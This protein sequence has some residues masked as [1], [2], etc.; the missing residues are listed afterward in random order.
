MQCYTTDDSL[1]YNICWDTE[2]DDL[3]INLNG[4]DY[5]ASVA[6]WTYTLYGEE[7]TL[8]AADGTTSTFRGGTADDVEAERFLILAAL[9]GAVLER[10]EL[11]PLINDASA[12]LKGMQTKM[13]SEEYIFGVGWNGADGVQYLTYNYTDAEWDEFV[14]SQGGKLT[15][16]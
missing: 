11:L 5:T 14:A 16:N 3:T 1:R 15:Y 12:T 8:T 10:Y 13:Y 7:I 9:E 4:T 2:N 6:D